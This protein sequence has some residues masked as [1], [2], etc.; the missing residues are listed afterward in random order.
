MS[1]YAVLALLWLLHLLPMPVLRFKGALLGELLYRLIGRRRKVGLRNLQLCFPGWPAGEHERVLRRHFRELAAT[2][3]AYGKLYFSSESELRA[4]IRVEG[5]EHIADLAEQK[6][7]I[8]LS[9]HFLGLDFGGLRYL[10]DHPG[11]SMY[12]S[13][14]GVFNVITLEIRRRFRNPMLIR[15]G[16]G[17]RPIIKALRQN[18]PFYY[19]PDQ[20]LGPKESIFVPFFGIPTATIPALGRLAGMTGAVVVPMITRL[21]GNHF[22]CRIFPAWQNFPTDDV[23]AD[24]RR[25]NA[26]IEEQIMLAPSQY[27]WLHRR[28]KTRPEGEA[29]L[30]N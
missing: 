16:D 29:S 14:R 28:F 30:Y 25:M 13:Q 9:P 20:D 21:E 18:I 15:R 23:E 10:M 6:P 19:L 2:L 8:F 12:S 7:F 5:F 26:F 27:Y 3:L 1:R 11:A 4:L 24:T 22:V 17:L